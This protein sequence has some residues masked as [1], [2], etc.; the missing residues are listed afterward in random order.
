MKQTFY[1]ITG[2]SLVVAI[3][4][5]SLGLYLNHK[6]ALATLC[7]TVSF[8]AYSLYMLCVRKWPVSKIANKEFRNS[9]RYVNK[10]TLKELSFNISVVVLLF[11]CHICVG[12][13]AIC[14]LRFY[15][16]NPEIVYNVCS[17]NFDFSTFTTL[18]IILSAAY[19]LNYCRVIKKTFGWV[20]NKIIAEEQLKEQIKKSFTSLDNNEAQEDSETTT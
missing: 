3:I 12:D 20:E 11:V 18:F 19:Q 17:L 5:N 10:K 14:A 7:Y 15:Y 2:L 8:F 4:F 9:L 13:I 16:A 1:I 6:Y